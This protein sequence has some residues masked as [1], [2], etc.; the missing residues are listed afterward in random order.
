[1]ILD[2]FSLAFGALTTGQCEVATM[3]GIGALMF[4]TAD[5]STMHPQLSRKQSRDAGEQFVRHPLG[6]ESSTYMRS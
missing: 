5:G 6:Q 4:R 2:V 3:L 1:M